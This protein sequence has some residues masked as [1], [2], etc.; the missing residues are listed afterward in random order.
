MTEVLGLIDLRF[1]HLAQEDVSY[2]CYKLINKRQD[3]QIDPKL[4]NFTH[5]E[6]KL[7]YK[8]ATKLDIE[9]LVSSKLLHQ[10]NKMAPME[11]DFLDYL[12]KC[13][14]VYLQQKRQN[15]EF[16]FKANE[17]DYKAISEQINLFNKES[18]L[19]VA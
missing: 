13:N 5:S 6:I 7:L 10:L 8:V 17:P 19:K 1:S 15:V 4:F 9:E 12:H 14:S 11:N 18:T 16:D 2:L 3:T